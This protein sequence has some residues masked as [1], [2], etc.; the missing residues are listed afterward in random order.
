MQP[1]Q[2]A[3]HCEALGQCTPSS[4]LGPGG[5]LTSLQEEIPKHHKSI[6]AI[7][8]SRDLDCLIT[9]GEDCTIQLH[10]LSG[11]VPTFNDVPL[12]TSFT[13][14]AGVWVLGPDM[15]VSLVCPPVANHQ[16]KRQVQLNILNTAG[17]QLA[18]LHLT[19]SAL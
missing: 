2:S 18:C 19:L 9:G 6:L 12:P 7:T 5:C 17:D 3:H 14:G 8:H 11:S 4:S 16:H 10:Y 1:L 15:Q 13:V